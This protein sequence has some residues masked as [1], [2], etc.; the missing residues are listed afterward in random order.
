MPSSSSS[1]ESR[2]R[3]S[4]SIFFHFMLNWSFQFLSISG[5]QSSF[6]NVSIHQVW[7]RLFIFQGIIISRLFLKQTKNQN[8]VELGKKL[9]SSVNLFLQQRHIFLE[10]RCDK[11]GLFLHLIPVCLFVVRLGS[12]RR[13]HH[14]DKINSKRWQINAHNIEEVNYQL[15]IA[16]QALRSTTWLFYCLYKCLAKHNF[17]ALGNLDLI[18]YFSVG[19]YKHCQFLW[20]LKLIFGISLKNGPKMGSK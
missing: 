6:K 15:L 20:P 13:D 18:T 2:H 19:K 9:R 12:R 14:H 1:S 7:E 17:W 16:T 10:V 3:P 4:V 11:T 8:D 5:K